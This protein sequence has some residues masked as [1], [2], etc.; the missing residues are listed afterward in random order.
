MDG[1]VHMKYESVDGKE[2][3][4]DGVLSISRVLCPFVATEMLGEGHRPSPGGFSD[5]SVLIRRFS[6]VLAYFLFW[7]KTGPKPCDFLSNA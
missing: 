7:A 1:F 3:I 5:I 6:D 4:L 2:I